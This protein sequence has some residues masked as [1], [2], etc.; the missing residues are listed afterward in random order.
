MTNLANEY[1][2]KR[3]QDVLGQ[4][5]H[6]RALQ[7]MCQKNQLP[8]LVLISGLSGTGKSTTARILAA[9]ASCK[10][11]DAET[12]NSCGV[13]S[14]C[15]AAYA[16]AR[17]GANFM[18]VD[19]GGK[20]L[21]TLIEEDMKLFVYSAPAGGARK[22]VVLIDEAQAV[23]RA[24]RESLLTLTENLPSTSM[25]IMTTTDIESLDLAIQT[26]AVKIFFAPL[27]VP[28][29]VEGVLAHQPHL[30]E[31]DSGRIGLEVLAK[32]SGGS[33]REMWQLIQQYESM[34][35]ELTEDNVALMLGGCTQADRKKLLQAAA[36]NDV[37]GLQKQWAAIAAKGA[38]PLRVGAQLMDDLIAAAAEKPEARDW[39]SAIRELSQALVYKSVPAIQAS[40]LALAKP[41]VKVEAVV[42]VDLVGTLMEKLREPLLQD[43]SN[44]L[45]GQLVPSLKEL[46]ALFDGPD[47]EALA[48]MVAARVA[49]MQ[50]AIA[51]EV[52]NR[53]IDF[54]PKFELND[55]EAVY[56]LVFG[57]QA[58]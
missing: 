3:F 25:V 35:L 48:E 37:A 13:C 15:E 2:P 7:R 36:K 53:V 57:R 56:R 17:D 50:M 55:T 44:Y 29:L 27:T 31:S 4:N 58:S 19:G 9:A 11:F 21:K 26:R 47:P 51:P 18:F 22:R 49:E 12:G 20:E 34:D 32:A 33:M 45:E 43:V 54:I 40:L 5:L 10:H 30:G 1:R 41:Q 52:T 46:L 14:E 8:S 16:G 24:A 28:Q 6:V 39:A 23:G 42:D 38:T